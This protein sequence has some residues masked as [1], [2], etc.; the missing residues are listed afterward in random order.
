MSE[1]QTA[2]ARVDDAPLPTEPELPAGVVLGSWRVLRALGE[3]GMGRVYLAEHVVI[4]RRAAIKV[5][6]RALAANAT[7]VERFFDEARAVNSVHHE[8]IVDVTDL[9]VTDGQPCIVMELLSGE[10]LSSRI[11]VGALAA[12]IVVEITI[13]VAEALGAAHDAGIVHRDLKPDNIML[14]SSSPL[15]LKVLDFGVAKLGTMVRERGLTAAGAIVGTPEFM[16]PEQLA[17]TAVDHR[18]D[19]YALGIVMFQMLTGTL[20]FRGGSFGDCVVQ[21]MTV[22]APDVRELAPD[23]PTHLATVIEQ[24]LSK[25]REARPASMADVVAALR[26]PSILEAPRTPQAARAARA[27]WQWMLAAAAVV[28]VVVGG[29]STLMRPHVDVVPA[30]A[31]TPTP[32]TVVVSSPAAAPAPVPAAIVAPPTPTPATTARTTTT[33][34]AAPAAKKPTR[35]VKPTRAPSKSAVVDP[36]AEDS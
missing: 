29:M 6:K 5:L 3:G 15:R 18:A 33:T 9:F 8:G 25:D 12:E 24:M 10:T 28:A 32:A 26:A 21:H 36:F 30:A 2:D 27:P 11:A 31:P 16:A 22:P 19:V 1:L 17:G 34:S 35:A 14:V 13:A 20:P 4:G 7:S 23:T